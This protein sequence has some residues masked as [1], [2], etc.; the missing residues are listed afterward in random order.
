M[1]RK[2]QSLKDN[3]IT[4]DCNTEV[5]TSV[6]VEDKIV[7][8]AVQTSGLMHLVVPIWQFVMRSQSL[9][10]AGYVL[11]SI[12]I[13]GLTSILLGIGPLTLQYNPCGEYPPSSKV[14]LQ[15]LY[16]EV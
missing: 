2:F 1:S 10:A 15:L 14:L 8:P 7:K 3:M 9:L 11:S 13:N 16:E 12:Y 5:T 6:H 4:P